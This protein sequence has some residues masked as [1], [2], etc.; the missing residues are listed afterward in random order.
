MKRLQQIAEQIEAQSQPPVDLWN[1]ENVG[2]IDI[3]IDANGLWFHEGDRIQRDKLVVLF[4]SILWYEQG[5]HYLVTPAEKL[6]IEV[7]DVP[8]LI[9]QIEYVDGTWVAVTNTHEQIIISESHP[10]VL[11]EFDGQRLP[12]V[13]VRYDLWARVNRSVYY[14]L[15]S[16]AVDSDTNGE[17]GEL[18]LHSASYRFCVGVL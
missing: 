7:E 12:Y 15:V 9:H 10:V 2:S 16:E 13:K 4:A 1:P 14:H 17:A 8:F 18:W 11:R 5:Q 3:R 6:A